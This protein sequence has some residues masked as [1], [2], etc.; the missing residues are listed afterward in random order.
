MVLTTD[1]QGQGQSDTFGED[2]D[3]GE[4][5]PAQTDGRPFVD[6]AQDAVNFFFSTQ[7][8][9]YRPVASCS[10][11][12]SHAAKQARR[13]TA[14]LDAAFN[15]YASLLDPSRVGIAG[16]SYGA[17]GVSY[18][19]QSDPRLKAIVA[20]DNLGPP[21]SDSPGATDP[22]SSDNS[23]QGCNDAAARRPAAIAKPALGMSADYFLDE[24]QPHNDTDPLAK[25][26]ESLAYSKAG[27]DTGEI[28][29]RGGTHYDFTWIPN[30]GLRAT[31]RGADEIAWYTTAWFDKYVKGDPG[32][33]KRLLTNRWRHNAQ[34]AAVD[35]GRDGNMMSQ[36]YQSR[37]DVRLTSGQRLRC[38]N[39]RAGCPG[40]VANDGVAGSYNFL[41]IARSPDTGRRR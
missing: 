9:P 15:P 25:S 40:L 41:S 26:Q 4:G 2:P 33:D 6:G 17:S 37:L 32:A 22:N 34:E 18:I 36:Y 7:D 10:T 23:E 30:P 39:L 8:H 11:G 12:T 13:A 19:G 3:R 27:V 5:F 20:W 1:P 14:G 24:F 21:A 38:E 16:H 28:I 31:L 29:I 35:P